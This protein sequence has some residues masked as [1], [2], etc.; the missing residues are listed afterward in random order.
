MDLAAK[1]PAASMATKRLLS[2][3]FLF[4]GLSALI[5]QVVWQRLLA[6]YYGVGPVSI[7]LIVSVYIAGLGFG[8]LIGG[9]LSERLT[10][11]ILFYCVIE[12][13]IGIFGIISPFFLRLLGRYTAGSPLT[14]S[15]IYMSLF[16][17]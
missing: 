11:R 6:T 10:R 9:H 8:A 1:I 2:A 13:C 17:L 7:A 15:F 5:Y 14:L 16:L 12:L 4:S 3:V